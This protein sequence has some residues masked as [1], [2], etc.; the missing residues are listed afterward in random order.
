MYVPEYSFHLWQNTGHPSSP[1]LF[2]RD[3]S[4]RLHVFSDPGARMF[5]VWPSRPGQPSSWKPEQLCQTR[6]RQKNI[7]SR[8][9]GILYS[10]VDT[11][12][13]RLLSASGSTR[14]P[15][16]CLYCQSRHLVVAGAAAW[17]K[18]SATWD[19]GQDL[20]LK[21]ETIWHISVATH[22]AHNP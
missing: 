11:W 8:F 22:M 14:E 21:C 17:E 16:E 4:W 2:R 7:F 12:D 13:S 9:W 18:P 19:P 20:G 5:G 10:I 6:G 1:A 15:K 3:T